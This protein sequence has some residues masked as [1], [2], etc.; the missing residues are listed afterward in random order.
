M[1]AVVVLF[2]RASLSPPLATTCI[3]IPPCPCAGV[4][5]VNQPFGIF[6]W[7]LLVFCGEIKGPIC[8]GG[9]ERVTG[10]QRGGGGRALPRE[11]RGLTT[12]TWSLLIRGVGEARL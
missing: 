6:Q 4:K 11:T 7:P 9:D 1:L 3:I 8:G 5:G 2:L 10:G 12:D